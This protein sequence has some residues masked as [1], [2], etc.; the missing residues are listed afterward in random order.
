MAHESDGYSED[1][2]QG[3]C[4]RKVLAFWNRKPELRSTRRL[5][6]KPENKDQSYDKSNCD[7]E[8]YRH[9]HVRPDQRRY[10]ERGNIDRKKQSNADTECL[11]V[12]KLHFPGSPEPFPCPFS[13]PALVRSH[14]S[15]R[16]SRQ[17][18]QDR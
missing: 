1:K 8:R 9:L 12:W 3:G 16:S 14:D 4:H 11:N 5:S 2:P 7:D 13:F 15:F 6:C 17:A 18:Q 10:C